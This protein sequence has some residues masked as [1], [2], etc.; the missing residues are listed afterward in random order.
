MKHGLF[1]G[2]N[3]LFE[4][5]AA[6]HFPCGGALILGSN[7]G[8]AAKFIYNGRL[9]TQDEASNTTW[10]PLRRSLEAAGIDLRECFFTDAW[11]CLHGGK[12]NTVRKEIR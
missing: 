4:G 1:P 12:S 9:L 8:C 5:E 7:F 10:A 3:G 11:P 6:A 2:G